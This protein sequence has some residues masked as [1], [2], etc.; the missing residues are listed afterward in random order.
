M[1]KNIFKE[2]IIVLLLCVVITLILGVIFYDYNPIGKVVPSKI[3]YTTP[4][5]IAEELKSTTQ[6]SET[7]IL[8]QNKIYTID[9][10]DLNA[11]KKS[12]AY[13]PSKENPFVNTTEGSSSTGAG[14]G[15]ST[16]KVNNSE[17]S[18]GSSES[19]G[20]SDKTSG[21]TATGSITENKTN[22][23]NNQAT[24]KKAKLK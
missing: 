13:D 5:N 21:E 3:A 1:I 6:P 20:Q 18:N 16:S 15:T 4:E 7:E 23:S 2:V 10:S 14:A 19:Q 22:D 17:N 24:G 12:K 11:Y 8:P 9:G